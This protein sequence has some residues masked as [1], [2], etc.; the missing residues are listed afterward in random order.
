MIMENRPLTLNG[1]M[2]GEIPSGRREV[3]GTPMKKHGGGNYTIKVS[4][5][6]LTA[7][8]KYLVRYDSNRK[9]CW[10]SNCGVE[11]RSHKPYFS[12]REPF[13]VLV[14]NVLFER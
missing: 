3:Y 8:E 13:T 2:L 5:D 6:L 4:G 1:H 7:S 12:D 14:G 10:A 9:V 11:P